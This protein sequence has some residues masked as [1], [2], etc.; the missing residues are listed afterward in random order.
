[1]SFMH[2]MIFANPAWCALDD[3]EKW[4]E[5]TREWPRDET[6]TVAW[7]ER[8]SQRFESWLQEGEVW[9]R[10]L[11]QH[12]ETRTAPALLHPE[13]VSWVEHRSHDVE[14]FDAWLSSTTAPDAKAHG[15]M[16]RMKGT[17]RIL[18]GFGMLMAEGPLTNIDTQ[19]PY[20]SWHANAMMHLALHHGVQAERL[21]SLVLDYE[22][23]W[24]AAMRAAWQ[25][26]DG[27]DTNTWTRTL[28]SATWEPTRALFVEYSRGRGKDNIRQ[29]AQRLLPDWTLRIEQLYTTT[30]ALYPEVAGWERSEMVWDALNQERTARSVVGLPAL[31]DGNL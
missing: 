10:A 19:S 14:R 8:N 16:T 4:M 27:M 21:Q 29:Q 31:N 26:R 18:R 5:V 6:Q 25:Q 15:A 20:R 7:W 13:W 24:E 17:W 23:V 28:Q 1:M 22:W 2:S 11:W 3:V 30:G 12:D 9:M